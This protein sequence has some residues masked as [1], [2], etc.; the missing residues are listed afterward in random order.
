MTCPAPYATPPKPPMAFRGPDIAKT[1]HPKPSSGPVNPAALWLRNVGTERLAAYRE[2]LTVERQRHLMA[3]R[4][5]EVSA[6]AETAR[7]VVNE[8][9]RRGR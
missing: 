7:A 1:A 5:R 3:S 8:I 4:C 9:L 2:A 6:L